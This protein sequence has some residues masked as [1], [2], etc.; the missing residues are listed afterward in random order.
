MNLRLA[1]VLPAVVA[2]A[3]PAAAHHSTEVFYDRARTVEFTGVLV[4]IDLINPHS[5]FQFEETKADGRTKLWRIEADHP[6]LVR[7]GILQQFGGNLEFE[8]GIKY[9]V[10]IE[11]A[12]STHDADGYL[13]SLVLPSGAVFTCC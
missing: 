9:T 12:W 7:R 13:K 6:N 8:P 11:P 4:K 1:S 2:L 5:W 3:A 10:R